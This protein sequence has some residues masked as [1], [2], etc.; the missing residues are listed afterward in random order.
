MFSRNPWL[1]KTWSNINLVVFSSIID[2]LQK[3]KLT[4]FKMNPPPLEWNQ[5]SLIM[6]N[7]WWNP[8]RSKT[9]VQD[10][11]IMIEEVHEGNDE[12]FLHEHKHHMI[13]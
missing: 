10:E 13:P 12:D 8:W 11:P 1:W 5:I 2:L 3:V 9:I 6:E 4:I 7:L